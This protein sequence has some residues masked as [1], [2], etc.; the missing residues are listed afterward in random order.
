MSVEEKRKSRKRCRT[1]TIMSRKSL[2][3]MLQSQHVC[4]LVAFMDAQQGASEGSC[5]TRDGG[6]EWRMS[7]QGVVIE[8]SSRVNISVSVSTKVAI[9]RCQAGQRLLGPGAGRPSVIATTARYSSHIRH[10]GKESVGIGLGEREGTYTWR[11][12]QVGRLHQ[13]RVQGCSGVGSRA[14]CCG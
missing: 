6:A 1:C 11:K 5:R 12:D 8:M 13:R 10:L 3:P 2:T 7:R 9:T 14:R 4:S